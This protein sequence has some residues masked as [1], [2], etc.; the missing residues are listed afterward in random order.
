MGG[1]SA[2]STR[3]YS[4]ADI[5]F[6]MVQNST[7]VKGLNLFTARITLNVVRQEIT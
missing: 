6:V 3:H 5:S 1:K 2:E 4:Q 7:S